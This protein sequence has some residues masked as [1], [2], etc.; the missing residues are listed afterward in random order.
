MPPSSWAYLHFDFFFA[1]IA[2]RKIATAAVTAVDGALVAAGVVATMYASLGVHVIFAA[3]IC[4]IGSTCIF[5]AV[6]STALRE[7]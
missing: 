5:V 4:P 2:R 1:R 6:V 7:S 3:A